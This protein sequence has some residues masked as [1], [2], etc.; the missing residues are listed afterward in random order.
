MYFDMKCGMN[1]ICYLSYICFFCSVL[2][3][4]R[5]PL[6]HFE[7]FRRHFYGFP[8]EAVAVQASAQ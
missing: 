6:L 1:E 2:P 7:G 3:P 8:R 4:H 5:S